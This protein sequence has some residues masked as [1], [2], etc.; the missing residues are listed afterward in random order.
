MHSFPVLSG[1]GALTL[2][3]DHDANH[4]GQ[5]AAG[6]CMHRWKA[7]GRQVIRLVPTDIG[8]FNDII[9]REQAS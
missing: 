5:V 2:L 8:D 3:V 4:A 7:A 1:I 6:E 9:R